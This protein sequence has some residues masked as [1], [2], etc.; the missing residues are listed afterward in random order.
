MNLINVEMFP[1]ADSED[2]I[3][4]GT[5]PETGKQEAYRVSGLT[6]IGSETIGGVPSEPL[7][8]ELSYAIDFSGDIGRGLTSEATQQLMMEQ[9]PHMYAELGVVR[10]KD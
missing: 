3:I 6:P 8:N 9:N 10:E 4:R 2:I 1:V 5:N 7:G